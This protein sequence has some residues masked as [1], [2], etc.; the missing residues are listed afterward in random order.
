MMEESAMVEVKIEAVAA[1]RSSSSSSRVFPVPVTGILPTAAAD[2]YEDETPAEMLAVGGISVRGESAL[3]RYASYKELAPIDS[4]LPITES[5]NGNF[6]TVTLL[7]LSSGI[8]LQALLLP[9]AFTSLGWAWGII[10]RLSLLYVWQLYTI[11]LLVDLHESA[12]TGTRFSR[13]AHLAI[14]AFGQTA[15]K[16]TA[17]FPTMYLSG[18]ACVLFIING[19]GTLE[20]FYKTMCGGVE[21]PGC[22]GKGPTG[23]E[24][25]LVFISLAIL[26]SLFFPN[27][28]SLSS[29]AAIGSV[30]GVAYCTVLWT[31]SLSK[32]RP[33]GV[34]Y[35]PPLVSTSKVDR[36]RDI[37]NALTLISLAFRGHNLILEIQGTMPSNGTPMRRRMWRGVMASYAVIALCH[38]PLA[39]AGYWTY[40]NLMPRTYIKGGILN[41]FAQFHRDDISKSGMGAIYMI[42]IIACLCNFQIYAIPTLDNWERIYLTKRKKSGS[43]WLRASIKV[44]FG[45]LTYLAAMAFPFLGSLAGV[46]GSITL[47]L[48]FAYPCFMWIAMKSTRRWSLLWC[49]NMALGCLGMLMCLVMAATT[50]WDLIANGLRAN[51]FKP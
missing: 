41:A 44:L 21:D 10:C 17:I 11:W 34:V 30:T 9:V 25:F 15:G 12:A 7:L 3:E 13:Y 29:I 32:G 49:L 36:F 6:F 42:I 28:N 38:F 5:R 1:S 27:M 26:V 43:K 39:I 19:G 22:H 31:L 45:G 48:T 8:G 16:L 23:A 46:V 37:V 4:Q 47:P 33:E 14:V 35:D 51:F 18:G 2:I 50:L 20:L 40:G 24:W